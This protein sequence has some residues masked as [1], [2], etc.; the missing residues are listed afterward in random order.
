M[1]GI[2]YNIINLAHIIVGTNLYINIVY[3]SR[4]S[5]KHP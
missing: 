3:K 2:Q 1:K 5:P 4:Q